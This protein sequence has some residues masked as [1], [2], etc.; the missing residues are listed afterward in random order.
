MPS[1]PGAAGAGHRT[2]LTRERII[3]AAVEPGRSRGHRGRHDAPARPAPRRRGD[4]ALQ[5]RRGQGRRCWPG[6]PTASPREF[7]LPSPD[8]RLADGRSGTAPWPPTRS[9]V[10]IP[11]RARSWSRSSTRGRR[12]SP[13]STRSSESSGARGSRCPTS[14]TPFGA[15]DSHLYGFTMQ[16]AS[17]PFDADDYPEV[18][19]AMAAG[20]DAERYPEPDGDGI[21]GRDSSGG[22]AAR[23]RVRA[24]P[25]PR[26]ARAAA[27]R[28]GPADA[29]G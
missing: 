15:L 4:V 10:A 21:D 13:T 6:S 17:W 22:C 8:V 1:E 2:P 24:R 3:D 7:A 11:G 16:V 27:A 5:A 29:R 14:P 25:A 26:R 19:A 12:G 20:L 28:R 18:A 9:C 23:L